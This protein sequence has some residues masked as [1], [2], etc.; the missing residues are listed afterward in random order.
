MSFSSRNFASTRSDIKPDTTKPEVVFS[1]L[2]V[3]DHEL[4]LLQSLNYT[5]TIDLNYDQNFFAVGFSA[6][7]YFQSERNQYAY[8]LVGF[9]KDWVLCGNKPLAVFSNVSPGSYQFQV[10][11]SNNDGVWSDIKTMS[12]HI[13]PP[14]WQTWW[15]RAF[16]FTLLISVVIALYR[17][18]VERRTLKAR[19]ESEEA[20]RRQIEAELNEKEAAFQLKISQTEMSALRSQMNPHFI[21]NC[22]NSIQ[23]F[24]A[25]NDAEKASNYL[26]KFSRLIRLV[27]ENSKSERVTLTNELETLRLYIEMEAMRFQQKV[28][29]AI[30]VATEIDTDSIQI[31]PLLL[32]PFVENAIWHGLMHKEEGG[33]VQ[34]SVQ[35]TQDNLLHVEIIDDGV[36]RQQAAEYKSKSATQNKSFGMKLTAERIEL[37]N[38]LYHTKTQVN[39]VDLIDENGKAK[40]TR[41]TIYI[42][43]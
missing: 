16:A 24:T 34:V 29:Y 37:I 26:T 3:F 28:S 5:K 27:L 40:G 1:F 8:Q 21:F 7:S 18:Q 35:Q 17:F 32:Q 2:K 4:H 14:F 6:L 22:L 30:E 12:I 25:Q 42:P 20:K 23:Y 15:F 31:P 33:T 36:G 10:K 9:N 43:I 11:G 41:V 39:V 19:L 38:Q 13:I